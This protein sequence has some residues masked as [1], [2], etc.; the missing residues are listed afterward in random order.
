MAIQRANLSWIIYRGDTFWKRYQLL[1]GDDVEDPNA[2]PV[3]LTGIELKGLARIAP[4]DA[5]WFDIPI[6]ITDAARGI[7][8]IKLTP[9]ETTA[10]GAQGATHSGRFDIQAKDTTTGD[11][12]TFAIG[13][14]TVTDDYTY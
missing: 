12:F 4:N 5:K 2:P 6:N 9:T 13:S 10:L 1:K 8:E 11:V 7:Y 3:N 14:I